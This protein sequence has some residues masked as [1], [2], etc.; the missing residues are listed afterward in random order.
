[1]RFPS[2]L[3]PVQRKIAAYGYRTIVSMRSSW[4][5]LAIGP[6]FLTQDGPNQFFF[7]K[8]DENN[9]LL[10]QIVKSQHRY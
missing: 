2:D 7:T 5:F 10:S 6:H 3:P 4:K 9:Y 8:N 1:M